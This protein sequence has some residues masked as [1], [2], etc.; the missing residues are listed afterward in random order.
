MEGFLILFLRSCECADIERPADTNGQG[1]GML[2][3]N[4]LKLFEMHVRVNDV[5]IAPLFFLS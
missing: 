1:D 3:C 2:S 4:L 5:I